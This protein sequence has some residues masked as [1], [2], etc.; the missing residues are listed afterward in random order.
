V[1]WGGGGG[2]GGGGR[3]HPT[4]V[5]GSVAFPKYRTS[6]AKVPRPGGGGVYRL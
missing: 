6:D 2:G 1:V 5:A 3:T 4:R